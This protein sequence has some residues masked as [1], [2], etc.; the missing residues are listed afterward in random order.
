MIK[1]SFE[2][3][4]VVDLQP[5]DL[6]VRI[7]GFLINRPILVVAVPYETRLSTVIPSLVDG[8]YQELRVHLPLTR[9]KGFRL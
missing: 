1:Y 8:T 2:D 5:G 6:C 9:C 7:T 3:L 4:R